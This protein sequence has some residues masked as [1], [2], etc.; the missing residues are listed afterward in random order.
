MFEENK[1][2]PDVQRPAQLTLLCILSFIAGGFSILGN[3]YF[4]AFQDQIIILVENG[5]FQQFLDGNTTLDFLKDVSSNFFLWQFIANA[6]SVIG[7]FLM[8]KL[9]SQGFHI[10]AISQIILIL[11]PEIYL[12]GLPFPILDILL[13]LVFVLLYFKNLRSIGKI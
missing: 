4:Y 8:W 12:P 3:L 6:T 10:Y 7:V 5:F 11:I 2:K 9:N 13:S 1:I